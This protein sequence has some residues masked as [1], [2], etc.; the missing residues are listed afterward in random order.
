M[1]ITVAGWRFM[2]VS[3]RLLSTRNRLREN[4][5]LSRLSYSWI[6]FHSGGI[7]QVMIRLTP[8]QPPGMCIGSSMA[9]PPALP[10]KRCPRWQRPPPSSSQST[11]L[12]EG[13]WEGPAPWTASGG[14]KLHGA[15]VES[16]NFPDTGESEDWHS[17]PEP[18]TLEQ[19]TVT[20]GVSYTYIYSAYKCWNVV[21]VLLTSSVPYLLFCWILLMYRLVWQTF[22]SRS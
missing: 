5:N 20:Y 11:T 14:C 9:Q 18:W 6:L 17:E 4:K 22:T 1:S 21:D 12:L 16:S 13:F 19:H 10:P 3:Y 8:I 2:E 15:C 7:T